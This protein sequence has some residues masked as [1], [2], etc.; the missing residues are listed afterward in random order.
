L[1]KDGKIAFT[2]SKTEAEKLK[3]GSKV[4]VDVQGNTMLP[5]LNDPHS[6]KKNPDGK[7]LLDTGMTKMPC[8]MAHS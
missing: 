3:R 8:P 1:V 4:M 7:P 6:R 2:G 5:G